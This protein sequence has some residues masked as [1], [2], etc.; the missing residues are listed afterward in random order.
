MVS[1]SSPMCRISVRS[2]SN[3]GAINI[4]PLSTSSRNQHNPAI[5][6]IPLSTSSRRCRKGKQ[7]LAWSR[8]FYPLLQHL[9]HLRRSS[10]V[11]QH[12]RAENVE[13]IEENARRIRRRSAWSGAKTSR[14]SLQ[15]VIKSHRS[16]TT[17]SL[18]SCRNTDA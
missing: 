3:L 11:K 6:I 17:E 18:W 13:R 8:D 12:T 14:G 4:I 16:S 1:L 10:K 2:S 7:A 15:C 9:R 5:N